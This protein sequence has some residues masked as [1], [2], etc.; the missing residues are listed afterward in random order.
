MGIGSDAA[1]LLSVNT[2]ANL[3]HATR[4]V[5]L[6]KVAE[7]SGWQAVIGR[8]LRAR[9][10]ELNPLR[11]NI[12]SWQ[13]RKKKRRSV[14]HGAGWLDGLVCGPPSDRSGKEDGP[15]GDN[16]APR[17]GGGAGRDRVARP[18]MGIQE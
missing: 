3:S 1:Q 7:R 8:R 12:V 16:H 5:P 9:K 2:N 17:R 14:D 11:W 4:R 6:E 10:R 15:M 13:V 18:A